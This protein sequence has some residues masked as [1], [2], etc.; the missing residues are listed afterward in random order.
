MLSTQLDNLNN[1][2]YVLN[3]KQLE[4]LEQQEKIRM[5]IDNL[6][7]ENE[8]IK[9]FADIVKNDNRSIDE[10][11]KESI[12][13]NSLKKEIFEKELN[14]DITIAE[15]IKKKVEEI[16]LEQTTQEK[17]E[18]KTTDKKQQTKK[19]KDDT[20][21]SQNTV[22]T[23]G[24]EIKNNNSTSENSLKTIANKLMVNTQTNEPTVENLQKEEYNL[25]YY[26]NIVN[27]QQKKLDIID[28]AIAKTKNKKEKQ[29]LE[30]QRQSL[31]E[32][33]TTNKKMLESTKQK[34]NQYKN[35]LASVIDTTIKHSNEEIVL[36]ASKY[37]NKYE[38]KFSLAQQQSLE[39]AKQVQNNLKETYQ[40][41][42]ENAKEINR[43]EKL[44]Y[45]VNNNSEQKNIENQIQNLKTNYQQQ[46]RE[47]AQK[48][49]NANKSIN[50][51]YS[52]VLYS[53]RIYNYDNP[54]AK[55]ANLVEKEIDV[56]KDRSVQLKKEA[57][58]TQNEQKQLELF[59]Q[60]DLIDRIIA[61]KQKYAIDLY[62]SA[63]EE[64]TSKPVLASV[65]PEEKSSKKEIEQKDVAVK[66]QKAIPLIEISPELN[67]QINQYKAEEAKADLKYN[68]AKQMLKE[69]DEHKQLAN[70]TYSKSKQK[71]ILKNIKT[72][73]EKMYNTFL[74]ANEIYEKSNQSKYTIY[75]SEINKLLENPN[76]L[77]NNKII[78]S[79]FLKEA[80]FYF[81]EAQKLRL[82]AK[83]AV[84][85]EDQI[86][87]YDKALMLE[88]K[89]LSNQ[90]YAIEALT[91]TEPVEFVAT[92]NLIKIDRLEALDNPVNV[93]DI[94]CIR[95]ERIISNL[96][97]TKEERQKLDEANNNQQTIKNLLD[98]ASQYE[99]KLNLA[100]EKAKNS[101]NDAERKKASK[102]IPKLEKE[103]FARKFTAA[104][105]TEKVNDNLYHLYDSKLSG[106]RSKNADEAKQGKQLGKKCK[107]ILYSG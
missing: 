97:L 6:K 45:T 19:Q 2:Q 84:T 57:I 33:L 79:Q 1:Y 107:Q 67:K 18:S 24:Q 80:D 59:H 63:R 21:I 53:V 100:K 87:I 83:A 29:Y 41:L 51:V 78:A 7:S 64:T 8:F 39:D 89:A 52:Q 65:K 32:E 102:Q 62:I 13:K 73:E 47:Y 36:S 95:T 101:T 14:A 76:V 5:D 92:N 105:L 11:T 25:Q 85:K 28:N 40:Q 34:I 3:A 46:F 54:N 44:K 61:E 20:L 12:N 43:L 70:R 99:S 58:A 31:V 30:E 104:E 86:A 23:G 38:I 60:A 35:T 42:Q 106:L 72:K 50:D 74:E 94:V 77:E 55:A 56:L 96:N 71:E 48:V 82:S 66:D 27:E 81:N 49:N 75:N 10:L 15:T 90:D 69:I 26:T 98:E 4:L 37:D 22:E 16:K 9:Q 103:Y 68:Q 88:K 91:N 17:P 93:D